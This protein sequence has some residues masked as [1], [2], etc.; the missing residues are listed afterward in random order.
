MAFMACSFYNRYR[1]LPGPDLAA[2][3]RPGGQTPGDA[4]TVTA[5]EYRAQIIPICIADPEP[6]D[7]DRA[8]HK[9][10]WRALIWPIRHVA[11]VSAITGIHGATASM[12]WIFMRTGDAGN[13][14]SFRRSG[15]WS[16]SECSGRPAAL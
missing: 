2:S 10:G 11:S 14:R 12:P 8:V 5:T 13:A 9:A 6:D 15:V 1:V 16:D 3:I 7:I 4:D